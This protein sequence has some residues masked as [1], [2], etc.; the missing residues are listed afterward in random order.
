MLKKVSILSVVMS[1]LVLT[2]C[3]KETFN[4]N[5]L[6]D[7]MILS[8]TLVVAA[9]NGEISLDD[10]VEPGD[11]VVF[12]NDNFIRLIIKD[13]TIVDFKLED[14]YDLNDM[15]SF[16]RGYEVGDMM[17]EDIARTIPIGL[18]LISQSVSP[19]FY[20]NLVSLDDGAPHD[21]PAFGITILEEIGFG[22]FKNFQVAV[23]SSG[24]MEIS[25]RNNLTIPLYDLKINL[26]N[27]SGR[28]P[29]GSELTIPAVNPGETSVATLDLAGKSLTNAIGAGIVILGSDGASNVLIDMDHN[30]EVGIY[31]YDLKVGSGTIIIP[32]Q[33]IN[34][35]DNKDT[36]DFDPGSGLEIER[37]KLNK[38]TIGYTITNYSSLSASVSLTMPTA[39]RISVPVSDIFNIGGNSSINGS[40]NVDNTEV[41]LS[42][43]PD[44]MYNRVPIV[45]SISVSSGGNMVDFDKSDLVNIDLDMNNPAVDY[46]KGYFGQLEESVAPET[47]DTGLSEIL[48]HLTGQFHISNP[49]IKVIYSNSFGIPIQ[50]DLNA[51]GKRASQTVNLDLSPFTIEYPTSLADREVSSTFSV[52]RENSSL[53]ELLSLPPEEIE[54]TVS[55]KMNPEGFTG[56]RDNLLFG[57][58]RLVASIEVEVP[59]ELWIHNLQLTDT[60]DNFLKTKDDFGPFNPENMDL[61]MLDIKASNGFP[62]GAT[63]RLMLYDSLSGN[64]NGTVDATSPILPAPV[65]ASGKVTAPLEST[66]S[67][68]FSKAFFE[69]S[70]QSDKIIF[71]FTLNTTGE[72][73]KDVRIYSDY[74]I[75]FN[76]YVRMKPNLEF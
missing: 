62:L 2:H 12:D 61:F 36:I 15:V 49:S 51:S 66:L 57:S 22:A 9:V 60:V 6:S 1:F 26:F 73:S 48:D 54:Y 70:R 68:E 42:T 71:M 10:L 44:Q 45:Y 8:P 53:P 63:L 43:D 21:F 13:D 24:T 52:T 72:G 75:S 29:I 74:S 25:I 23:F 50:V 38:G 39:L 37:L 76:G 31:G 4:L 3:V 7:K 58:S 17:I 5:N 69:A 19:A 34:S 64:I 59:L 33:T 11:T 56:V 32:D 41:D 28:S 16:N 30:I 14:Y 55:G 46:V 40:I 65:D 20:S 35:L 47:K 27:I 67:I 18:D